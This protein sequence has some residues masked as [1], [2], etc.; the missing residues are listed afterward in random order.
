MLRVFLVQEWALTLRRNI[1]YD[2]CPDVKKNTITCIADGHCLSKERIF[3]VVRMYIQQPVTKTQSSSQQD[4]SIPE[5]DSDILDMVWP[6]T[7]SP[8]DPGKMSLKS[9]SI[10]LIHRGQAGLL[11]RNILN[12]RIEEGGRRASS[13]ILKTCPRSHTH[14]PLSHFTKCNYMAHT[15][16][17]ERMGNVSIPGSCVPN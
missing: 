11:H 15:S 12:S 7:M 4:R 14:H 13:F 17:Q 2:H 8:R 1:L 6:P 16:L 10:A 9:W 5:E 3:G